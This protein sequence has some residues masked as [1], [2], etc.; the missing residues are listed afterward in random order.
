M[1]CYW[2]SE[3]E[4]S[5]DSS[6]ED[7][8]VL[9]TLGDGVTRRF[10]NQEMKTL[11]MYMFMALNA[12]TAYAEMYEKID[13]QIA[14][15]IYFD[16]ILSSMAR[17]LVFVMIAYLILVVARLLN[18]LPNGCTVVWCEYQQLKLDVAAEGA[19]LKAYAVSQITEIRESHR[20]NMIAQLAIGVLGTVLIPT[21][22]AI[23]WGSFSLWKWNSKGKLYQQGFRSDANKMGMGLTGMLSIAMILLAPIYG[24]KRI[25]GML[26]PVLDILRQLPAATWMMDWIAKWWGGEVEFDD[27]PE[28]ADHLR[29]EMED[30]SSAEEAHH[31]KAALNE[32]RKVAE[33]FKPSDA[34]S[35]TMKDTKASPLTSEEKAKLKAAYTKPNEDEQDA[36][37]LRKIIEQA[38][39]DFSERPLE[40]QSEQ[41]DVIEQ[42]FE[43][44]VARI[45]NRLG[46]GKCR[47]DKWEDAQR[48]VIK[49][50]REEIQKKYEFKTLNGKPRAKRHTQPFMTSSLAVEEVPPKGAEKP[51]PQDKCVIEEAPVAEKVPPGKGVEKPVVTAEAP[52][53]KGAEKLAPQ[54]G[55]FS[56]V[57]EGKSESSSTSEDDYDVIGEPLRERPP[58]HIYG[59]DNPYL[60]QLEKEYNETCAKAYKEA[61]PTTF[62]DIKEGAETIAEGA[63]RSALGFVYDNIYAFNVTTEEDLKRDKEVVGKIAKER[64]KTVVGA[65]AHTVVMNTDC[66]SKSIETYAT[67]IKG[68]GRSIVGFAI[69]YFT[70]MALIGAG[71]HTYAAMTSGEDYEPLGAQSRKKR[72]NENHGNRRGK[73]TERKAGTP[74]MKD[75]TGEDLVNS[76]GVEDEGNVKEPK[77]DDNRDRNPDTY[78]SSGSEDSVSSYSYSQEED[79]VEYDHPSAKKWGYEPNN[80]SYYVFRQGKYVPI[81]DL[82]TIEADDAKRRAIYKSKTR[83]MWVTPNDKKRF[84]NQAKVAFQKARTDTL[85]KQQGYKPTALSSGIYKFFVD[86][87]YACTATHVSNRLYVVLHCLSEHAGT[88]YKAVNHAN[89][90]VLKGGD[91]VVVTKDIGY[92]PVNGI[93]SPFKTK[94]F[95]VLKDA[96]IVSIYGYGG[97]THTEP[98]LK[99]GFA[100]PLGWCNADTE[101]GDC[102]SPVLDLGGKIVGFWTHGDGRSFGRFDAI[103]PEF[104]EQARGDNNA[105]HSGLVFQSRLPCQL[106][107]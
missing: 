22:G 57:S 33:K 66:R 81:A 8:L 90:L 54:G 2:V 78:S 68:F 40:E 63:L 88:L 105:R 60:D 87:T 52:P 29:K 99:M 15:A 5:D 58:S 37:K 39:F 41:M 50:M 86:G 98:E 85:L 104:L 64:P 12:P 91:L 10:P 102:S 69:G 56:R 21:V 93:A 107:L 71:K 13:P 70:V 62:S 36:E 59:E 83:P 27:L 80:G 4:H 11:F 18:M 7:D 3:E 51:F 42:M 92:F 53:V 26:R 35:Q 76:S 82:P 25:G 1:C 38:L 96:A 73:K 14:G 16:F 47:V 106:N 19:A 49:N 89:T 20:K 30:L 61:H 43:A 17:C 94:D 46:L 28:T 79:S 44:G 97:G 95:K 72:R 23:V 34:S 75:A 67:L 24:A 74:N 77:T 101:T 65:F 100:S 48:D 84:V 31:T 32:Y 45:N 103:T 9:T 55:V 6:G